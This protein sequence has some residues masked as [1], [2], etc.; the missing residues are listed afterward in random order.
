MEEYA[1]MASRLFQVSGHD[2]GAADDRAY[3]TRTVS[4]SRLCAKLPMP[5][6]V[7]TIR[8]MPLMCSAKELGWQSINF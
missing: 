2:H 1:R 8:W 7:M 3:R 6:R 4:S 5:P